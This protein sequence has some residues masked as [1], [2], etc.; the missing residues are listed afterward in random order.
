MTRL[1]HGLVALALVLTVPLVAGSAAPAAQAQDV[2]V[3][4]PA[5][6]S[7]ILDAVAQNGARITVLNVWATW[8]APCVE[9]F[10]HFV[11]FGREF[12]SEGVQVTFVSVDF[13]EDKSAAQAFL[14]EQG[15]TERTFLKDEKTTPFVNAFSEEW[16]GAVPAT[17]VYGPDGTLLDFWE[18]KTDYATL[19]DRVTKHLDDT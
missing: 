10:P 19:K 9:E 18:E 1:R 3:V 5:T 6:H 13:V 12:A 7:E 17:F 4:E 16:S 11:R 8:C 14:A 2:P 15:V